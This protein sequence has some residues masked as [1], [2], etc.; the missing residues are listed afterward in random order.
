MLDQEK[1]LNEYYETRIIGLEK[2][3]NDAELAV[4]T[5]ESDRTEIDARCKD[6]ARRLSLCLDEQDKLKEVNEKLT[7][8][9]KGLKQLA[10]KDGQADGGN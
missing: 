2:E 6:Y 10:R 3:L 9:N 5:S 7:S 1:K 4:M 8:E